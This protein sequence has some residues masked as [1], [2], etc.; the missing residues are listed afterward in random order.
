MEYFEPNSYVPEETIGCTSDFNGIKCL[1]LLKVIIF[2]Q[3]LFQNTLKKFKHAL[4]Q[5]PST[6]V[7][8]HEIIDAFLI[9]YSKNSKIFFHGIMNCNCSSGIHDTLTHILYTRKYFPLFYFRP[10]CL[11]CQRTNLDNEIKTIFILL[12]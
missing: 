5:T 4:S 3:I 8:V 11:Q 1:N 2:T 10:I 12:C 6:N 7:K 9:F